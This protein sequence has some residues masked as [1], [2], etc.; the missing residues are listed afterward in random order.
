MARF[1]TNDIMSLVGPAPRYDLAESI[2]PDLHLR[3]VLG[4]DD[5]RLGY[6]SAAGDP[7]LRAV[8]AERHL[9]DPNDVV[10]TAGGM[11]ALFL[12]AFILCER[13][14]EAVVIEPL[15]PMARTVLEA[16]GARVRSVTSRFEERYQPDLKAVRAALSERTELVSLASPQNP[17]G[18]AIPPATIRAILRMEDFAVCLV[19]NLRGRRNEPLS[20]QFEELRLRDRRRFPT[21]GIY[22]NVAFF[23]TGAH[24]QNP[25]Q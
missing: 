4:P 5:I 24:L 21:V 1:P 8:I 9:V 20:S 14:D 7:A 17:S 6:G 12:L 3:D 23:L 16:V 22:D 15:F 11:H 25:S 2:G 13:G 18:V 10:V 19:P